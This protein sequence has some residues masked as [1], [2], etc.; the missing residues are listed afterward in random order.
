MVLIHISIL[1]VTAYFIIRADHAAFQ[2]IR[3]SVQT[4]DMQRM[5]RYHIAVALGLLGMIITG[6]LM[7]NAGASRFGIEVFTSNPAF[8]IKM[9][10]VSVLVINAFVISFLMKGVRGVAYS[11]L[12]T[13][14]K[15]PL[16][17]SGAVSTI[18]WLGALS[19]AFFLE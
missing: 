13:K 19:M 18:A 9:F 15:I 6:S 8:L 4:L 12:T 11:A 2:W 10:F 1:L 17:I 14:Q 7:V 5:A 16:M 3:G